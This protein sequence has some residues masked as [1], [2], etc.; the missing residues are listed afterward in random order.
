MSRAGLRMTILRA[1]GCC[2]LPGPKARDQRGVTPLTRIALATYSKLPTLNE[3]DRLL[4][5]AL[6][7]LGVTAVPA[8]WDAPTVCW[9]EF[10]GLLIR[11]A[12]DYHLRAPEFLGWIARL[13][14][15]GVA[16]WNPGDVLRW[17]HHKRYLRD[18][19][20]AGGGAPLPPRR[21]ARGGGGAPPPP[22]P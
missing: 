10:Q 20:A 18:L 3:D 14:R 19:A 11:S 6:A 9:N 8:V 4:I 15:A 1:Q 17:N 2:N 7:D 13:E 22:P 5:P 21:L 12:W 16:V